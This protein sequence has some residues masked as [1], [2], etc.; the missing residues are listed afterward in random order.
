MGISEAS[1]E[2]FESLKYAIYE[3]LEYINANNETAL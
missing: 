2:N 1:Y 3:Y